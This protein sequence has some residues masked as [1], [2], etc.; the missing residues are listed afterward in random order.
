MLN[1]LRFAF[2]QLLKNPGFTAVA[3]LTLAL[4]IGA[5]TAIFSVVNGVL[6]KPLSYERPGQLVYLW[7]DPSGTGQSQNHV[8][9][10]VFADW[11]E[12]CTSFEALALI[13]DAGMNLTGEGRPERLTGALVS[14]TLLD[15]LR[16]RPVLGRGFLPDEDQPGK[17]KVVVLSHG[18]WRG[19]FNGNSNLVGRVIW[20]NGEGFTVIGVLPPKVRLQHEFDFLMPFAFGAEEWHRSRDQNAFQVIARL[21]PGVTLEAARAEMKA[22]SKRLKPVYPS[23]KRDW[24]FSVVPMHEQLTGGVRQTLLV[25]L[26]AVGFVL[27]ICC[28]NVANLLLARTVARQKEMAIRAALGAGRWQVIRQLLTES[29]V[30]ALF[31]GTL[32]LALAFWGVDALTRFAAA[33]LPRI[34]D[35]AVDWRVFGFAS[36]LSVL[37]GLMF[38]SAAALQASRPDLTHPLKEGGRSSASGSR[39]RLRSALI[40]AEVTTS[41]VLLAG[42]GLLLKSFLRL[43]AVSPGFDPRN[44]LTMYLPGCEPLSEQRTPCP[45]SPPTLPA[46]GSVAGRRGGVRRD[47]AADDWVELWQFGAG[48]RAGQPARVRLQRTLG[49][50]SGELLSCAGPSSR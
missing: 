38:G 9:G 14:A 16:L 24:S 44:V 11:K 8:A 4:G 35:V 22:L 41:L 17:D 5:N 20:L 45:V 31:G 13:T 37:T 47:D 33:N 48:R 21:K 49:L 46:T 42:A 12:H 30:L 26:G 3:V 25:L 6:L 40:V 32:G 36:L 1:D 19:R 27:L 10:G 29:L 15:I 2:R 7:E 23:S 50:R 43:Q 39:N 34:D 28:V 18:F